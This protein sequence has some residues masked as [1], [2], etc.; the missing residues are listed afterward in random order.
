MMACF[1]CSLIVVM[2][3]LLMGSS[4]ALADRTTKPEVKVL[5]VPTVSEE[6]NAQVRLARQLIKHDDCHGAVAVLESLESSYPGRTI[7]YNLLCRCYEKLGY[8]PKLE[9]LARRMIDSQPNNYRYHLDLAR[10]LVRLEKPEEGLAS[11][12][13]AARLA[14]SDGQYLSVTTGM[15]NAGFAVEALALMDSLR[16]RIENPSAFALQRGMLLEAQSLYREAVIE[17]LPLLEDTTRDAVHAER[18]LLALLEFQSSSEEVEAVLL[19]RISDSGNARALNT[20]TGFYLK[21]GRLEEAYRHT[22]RLDSLQGLNGQALVRF[23]RNCRERR[24]YEL[25]ARMGKH[26]F[27]HYRESAV[28]TEAYL[29]YADAL[30]QMGTYDAAIAIY[31]SL[32]AWA[33]RDQEK[34]EGLYHIGMI[35]L[36]HLSDYQTARR[37]FDSVVTNYRRGLGYVLSHVARPYCDLRRGRLDRAAA[38]FQTLAQAQLNE[39]LAEKIDY[40]LAVIDY[41]HGKYDSA[42]LALQRLMVNYPRGYYVNDAMQLLMVMDRIGQDEELMSAFAQVLVYDLRRMPD[43]LKAALEFVASA[44][45]RSLADFALYRL[46]NISLAENDDDGVLS[47]VQR[48]EEEFPQSYYYP[49]GL[50]ARADLYRLDIGRVD[51]SK[52]I[53][54]Q[55]LE[56]FPNYP[57]ASEVRQRLRELEQDNRIG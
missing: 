47:C 14:Q 53:Y 29:V 42:G 28:R 57:F 54:R 52:L 39:E 21:A 7:I 44:P 19:E 38:G 37:Y 35:Y 31:D 25:A 11:Y 51:E 33:P 9:D 20:L 27:A 23:M 49:F 1:R 12:R 50:K 36:D 16:G 56:K 40:H 13:E 41:C 17:Y 32:V 2:S 3:L 43:S 8:Q 5:A 6:F 22:L 4:A 30:T 24:R 34:G 15:M 45:S 46:L 18:R 55:L 26:F 10:V 48:L